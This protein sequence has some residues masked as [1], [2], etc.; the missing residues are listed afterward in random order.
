MSK[1]KQKKDLR[2]KIRW[3]IVGVLVLLLA[4]SF[5]DAPSFFNKGIDKVNQVGIGI[6]TIPEKPFNLGLDLAGG[7]YLIFEADITDVDEAER[8]DALNGV[9]DIIEK[10]LS[11]GFGVTDPTIQTAKVGDS[12]RVIVELPGVTDVN[13]AI[14]LIGETP[15]LEFKEGTDEP[16]RE[17]TIEER[18]ELNAFNKEAEGQANAIIVR[19]QAGE[20]FGELAKEVSVDENSKNNNGY[21]GFINKRFGTESDP[22]IWAKN[23][24][25]GDISDTAIETPDGLS[26][27]QRG[28]ER[29]GGN[30][31]TTSHILICSAEFEGCPT[32]EFATNEE[33]RAR[34]Q[35]LFEQANAE[36]F[37]QLATAFSLE[38]G[39]DETGGDLGTLGRGVLIKE[40][41]D[42]AYA[43]TVGDI[44]GP[45][46][47]DFGYHVIYKRGEEPGPEY[48][49]SRILVETKIETDFVPNDQ[50]KYTGLTGKQLDRAEVL[51]DGQTGEIIV[52][53]T[54][55]SEGKD[56][57][58]EITERNFEKQIAIFLDGQVITD[59]VVRA[60]IPDGQTVIS[61][62]FTFETGKLL[63]Q[64]LNAG[65]LPVPIELIG[66]QTIGASLGA[67][68]LEKSL[69]AG[70]VGLLI[71]MI[72]MLLYYRLPGALAIIALSLYLS[73]TLAI[74]KLIGA[75]LTLAGIAGIILSIGM[76]VDANVLI[77]ER[78]KEELKKKKTLHTAIEE[79]FIRAWSAIRDGNVSTIITCLLL[80]MFGSSFVQSFAV[81]LMI[82]V[83]MSMFSA[84]TVTKVLLRFVSPWFKEKGNHLFLGY[85]DKQ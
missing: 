16:P 18:E 23:A 76:A 28:I 44:I 21:L 26:I 30:L 47:T 24:K 9:V 49:L 27:F 45:V 85:T 37:E 54:F 33:A 57:F 58:K 59:P 77:F 64:R 14:E 72:F 29:D 11:G 83:L 43:A 60:V 6:P 36:N 78:L 13:G 39:A 3:G 82:G 50:W 31:I 52:Q 40:Y 81:T 79:G 22:Y 4:T 1:Y 46:E 15:I 75:T 73:L 34:A 2:S 35:E 25:E 65:A 62:G 69:K 8:D 53:L 84:I 7:A 10:R 63:A 80:I 38:P 41:E 61:G 74:F 66:Q 48:E 17:L 51:Q 67:E 70:A 12:Y 68:S 19:L 55:D 5:F 42:A 56:L 32:Q 20:E 71:V